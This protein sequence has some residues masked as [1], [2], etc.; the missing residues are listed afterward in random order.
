M[1]NLLRQVEA[2]LAD[3]APFVGLGSGIVID[4]RPGEDRGKA[5]TD[6]GS[7]SETTATE[8]IA[9]LAAAP[10]RREPLAPLLAGAWD[11]RADTRLTDALY[12]ELAETLDTVVVTTDRR[13]ARAHPG[14]HEVA[15]RTDL[16]VDR[17]RHIASSTWPMCSQN[18]SSAS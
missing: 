3:V 9:R 16:S 14:N 15:R 18:T 12:V 13:L 5:S 8:R 1:I 17:R 4:V 6:A 2:L 11:R 10:I 7:I